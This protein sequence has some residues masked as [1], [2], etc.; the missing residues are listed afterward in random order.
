[1]TSSPKMS[2][3]CAAAT[4]RLIAREFVAGVAPKAIA[5][6]LNQDGIAEVR[7]TDA[8]ENVIP[9]R[10]FIGGVRRHA[11]WTVSFGSKKPG[12]WAATGSCGIRIARCNSPDR[13]ARRRPAAPSSSVN[14]R[15]DAWPLS[16]AAGRS[17]GPMSRGSR[18]HP[19][20]WGPAA[21]TPAVPVIAAVTR[22]IAQREHPWRGSYKDLCSPRAADSPLTASALEG[23]FLTSLDNPCKS[24]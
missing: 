10:T 7:F 20:R 11:L 17:P 1:M 6:R 15:T 4:A 9:P 12:R 13:V 19:L 16:I 24:T 5:R 22:A 23:T 3:I 2:P 21:S 14:G 18:G 8:R